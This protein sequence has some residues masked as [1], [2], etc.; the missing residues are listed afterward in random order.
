MLERR[1]W[2]GAETFRMGWL[3]LRLAGRD[4][5]AVAFDPRGPRSCVGFAMRL[6]QA[7][8]QAFGDKSFAQS[9]TKELRRA[10]RC[11]IMMAVSDFDA[12]RRR[13]ALQLNVG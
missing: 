12:L 6:S 4:G 11:A 8:R 9:L 10:L 5:E 7:F 2:I 13:L 1:N 3:V